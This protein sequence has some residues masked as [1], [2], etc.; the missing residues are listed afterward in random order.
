[1]WSREG[2]HFSVDGSLKSTVRRLVQESEAGAT[3]RELVDWLKVRVHNTL[4]TL[5]RAGD[6]D[7]ERVEALFVYL[8]AEKSICEQ[9]LLR[10]REWVAGGR[11]GT[12]GDGDVLV[13]DAV[14]I[15]VLL[16]LIDHPG[17]Q[18]ADVVRR[19]RGHVPPIPGEQV[20]A[21]FTRYGLGGKGGP[22]K[23]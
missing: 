17:S 23:H 6:I 18:P 22:S 2:V 21:V 15:Q 7:R 13:S 4:L 12:F 5:V 16:T 3:H 11:P 10:R 8:H 20:R 19:L 1:M 14:V 9:Q